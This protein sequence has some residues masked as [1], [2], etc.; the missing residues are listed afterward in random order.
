MQRPFGKSSW[1]LHVFIPGKLYPACAEMLWSFSQQVMSALIILT[2]LFL[3]LFFPRVFLLAWQEP[4][5][6]WKHTDRRIES[7]SVSPIQWTLTHFSAK[8]ISLDDV[9]ISVY[10]SHG[11]CKLFSP[12]G[13]TFSFCWHGYPLCLSKICWRTQKLL[14]KGLTR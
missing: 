7:L 1:Y 11:N 2:S 5:F 13:F 4:L 10:R 6:P 8:I 12:P 9:W 3:F 14:C